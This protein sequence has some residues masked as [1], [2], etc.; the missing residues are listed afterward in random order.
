MGITAW[1]VACP[2]APT[3]SGSAACGPAPHA[4]SVR[5]SPHHRTARLFEECVD[6]GDGG[7]AA[8]PRFEHV[9][10]SAAENALAL[11]TREG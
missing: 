7:S 6:G 11:L 4:A 2:P 10:V 9:E 5:Q 8:E 1:D 3:L